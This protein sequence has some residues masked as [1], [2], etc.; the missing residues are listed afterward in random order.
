M[1]PTKETVEAI[2]R[3]KE[4]YKAKLDNPFLTRESELI[5]KAKITACGEILDELGY[6]EEFDISEFDEMIKTLPE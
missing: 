5:I 4:K 3:V 6:E 1:K 2:E